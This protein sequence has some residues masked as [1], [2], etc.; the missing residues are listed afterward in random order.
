[1]DKYFHVSRLNLIWNREA[2]RRTEG[3]G[4]G[5]GDSPTNAWF[6]GGHKKSTPGNSSKRIFWHRTKLT[7]VLM[8]SYFVVVFFL[9]RTS[10]IQPILDNVCNFIDIKE[11]LKISRN[12][13]PK[14]RVDIPNFQ[15]FFNLDCAAQTTFIRV[16]THE[17]TEMW[18]F[19]Q[20]FQQ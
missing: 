7:T 18:R 15:D 17:T 1:M 9:T 5:G 19:T 2:C 14:N 3:G 16:V 12:L 4:G 6:G 20:I 13:S 10:K 11:S 8:L